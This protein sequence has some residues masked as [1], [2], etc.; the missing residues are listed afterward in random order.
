[1]DLTELSPIQLLQLQANV[2]SEL[3]TR[4]IVR[5]S[6]APLGD[7][8]EWLVANVFDMTLQANSRA[9]FDALAI[10]GKRVQ[11][12]GR[13]LIQTNGSRQLGVIRNYDQNDF[14]E[15]I[16]VL[17]NED[18]S[19]REAYRIPHEVVGKYAV[20]RA[21]QNGHILI[22][23]GAVL[24][25]PEVEEITDSIMM[26]GIDNN[27]LNIRLPFDDDV[28][29]INKVRRKLDLWINRQGQI[30]ARILNAYLWIM[31]TGQK[32]ITRQMI[33]DKFGEGAFGSN[34]EQMKIIS[35]R[36]HAKIFDLD[37]GAVEIWNPIRSYVD[38]Y[39]N[40]IFGPIS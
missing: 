19:V 29:E 27:K 21:H 18:F 7:Y 30:N 4:E 10:N 11:I 9:G 1:M 38:K 39:E 32:N 35:P 25:D 28:F 26:N 12:K 20:F 3:K 14:D 17:Y 2:I 37:G 23:N 16:A 24:D 22:L 5:T 31:R 8:T 33:E 34:F 36:N 40:S 13:R 15:L 6:N